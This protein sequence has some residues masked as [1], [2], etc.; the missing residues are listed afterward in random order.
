MLDVM[1]A[2]YRQLAALV[3]ANLGEEP[4]SFK[5]TQHDILSAQHL[6]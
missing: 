6:K 4:I 1:H 3:F 5:E 2:M